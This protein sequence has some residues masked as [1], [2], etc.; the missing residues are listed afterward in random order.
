MP[1][2][3]PFSFDVFL[4]RISLTGNLRGTAQT[5]TNRI[6]EL[7]GDG[8]Q[9]L[10]AEPIGSLPQG[11]AL[12]GFA[13]SD[14]LVVL[15]YGKHIKGKSPARVLQDVRD[16]LSNYNARI[17]KKNGQAVTLYFKTWPNVDIV[18]A[19]RIENSGTFCW[20][21]IPDMTRGEWISSLPAGHDAAVR[22]LGRADRAR[23][24][25]MKE[26]NRVH[27]GYLQSFHLETMALGADPANA[28]D[29]PWSVFSF[30][31]TAHTLIQSPLMH[32]RSPYPVV[33]SYLDPTSRAEATKRIET[34]IDLS[35][36]AWYACRIKDDH[37]SAIRRYMQI[38]GSRFPV[39]G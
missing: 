1:Y 27:S 30:F 6:V 22:Q 31:S 38:F 17:V 2:T 35:R 36:D 14:A 20:Y 32:P 4:D 25:M 7:L 34:A 9:I 18:P 29:W 21:E 23:I 3:V 24:R 13:D 15:H 33:D 11:T 39:Y 12:K 28:G 8:F 26:W 19:A 10:A 16:H 5:R 37:E